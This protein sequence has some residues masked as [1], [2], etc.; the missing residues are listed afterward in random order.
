MDAIEVLNVG[1]KLLTLLLDH[2][3]AEKVV[4]RHVQHSQDRRST[5]AGRTGAVPRRVVAAKSVT[6]LDGEIAE[7]PAWAA[8]VRD[9][10]RGVLDGVLRIRKLPAASPTLR[11]EKHEVLN[12]DPPAPP[13]F[14]AHDA[15]PNGNGGKKAKTVTR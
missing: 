5:R 9:V 10:Q 13:P 3:R 8:D 6:L 7:L 14:V 15:T 2:P 1:G 4:H 11:L 12:I